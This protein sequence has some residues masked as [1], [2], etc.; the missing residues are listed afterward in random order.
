M[1]E[2]NQIYKQK[3]S[4][5]KLNWQYELRYKVIDIKTNK[6]TLESLGENPCKYMLTLKEFEKYLELA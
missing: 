2:L 4:R 1:I 3:K 5:K 6:I